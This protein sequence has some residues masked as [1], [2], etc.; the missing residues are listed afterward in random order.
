MAIM[1]HVTNFNTD[2]HVK[3]VVRG[4]VDPQPKEFQY[5]PAYEAGQRN[6][7]ISITYSFADSTKI[8]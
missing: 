8:K 4:Q 6:Y 5:S 2:P 7:T 3:R 1:D